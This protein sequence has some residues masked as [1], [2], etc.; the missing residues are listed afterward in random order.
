VPSE[1]E[2][3]QIS[4]ELPVYD[5]IGPADEPDPNREVVWVV[6]HRTDE[7]APEGAP[8]HTHYIGG[9]CG[10]DYEPDPS[11]IDER[12]FCGVL[13]DTMVIRGP[14]VDG[15]HQPVDVSCPICQRLADRF[16]DPI[17]RRRGAARANR[18]VEIEFPKIVLDMMKRRRKAQGIDVD[19]PGL[20]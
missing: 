1:D 13:A 2:D 14:V 12:T 5:E 10:S 17:A 20:L 18:F 6:Q 11:S 15:N 8:L 7:H 16:F 4:Y 3:K 19:A 9:D